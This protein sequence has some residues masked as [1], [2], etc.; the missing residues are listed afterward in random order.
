MVRVSGEEYE[1]IG[2]TGVGG[3]TF[4]ALVRGMLGEKDIEKVKEMFKKGDRKK[5]DI[6]VGDIVGGDIGMIKSDTTASNL[7]KLARNGGYDDADLACGIANLIGQVV[8]TTAV[9][10]ARS[11]GCKRIVLGGK[12]TLMEQVLEVVYG[13]AELYGVE[14]V[15]PENAEFLSVLGA[16][17]VC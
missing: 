8:A 15:V 3:G 16:G 12:F 7:G 14:I 10:G 1:H 13:V 2:G 5:V 9:F 6:S 17:G 11:C 4:L